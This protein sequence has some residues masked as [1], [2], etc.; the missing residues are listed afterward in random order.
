VDEFVFGE[1]IYPTLARIT[2]ANYYSAP[3]NRGMMLG[4]FNV[5]Y[6]C[7]GNADTVWD[8]LRWTVAGGSFV[9][10]GTSL[11]T[12]NVDLSPVYIREVDLIGSIT[13]GVERWKGREAH[14]FELVIDMLQSGELSID[15][16][17]THRFPFDDY[18]K[19]VQ[20]AS[21]KSTGAIKVTLVD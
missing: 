12:M 3:Y 10:I 21:D 2:G 13:F 19:A 14:T 20:A 7:V 8:G 15:G 6:D 5:V 18:R 1:D 4:G 9:L 11:N 16:L 17:I